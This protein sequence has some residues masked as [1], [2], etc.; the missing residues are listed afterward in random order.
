MPSAYEKQKAANIERNRQLLASLE[1]DSATTDLFKNK[2][3]KPKPTPKPKP[4][5]AAPK[6]R[7][8]P[9]A[10]GDEGPDTKAQ[11]VEAPADPEA[12]GVRRSARNAGKSVDYKAEQNKSIKTI[13]SFDH[14]R[15]SKNSGE[16]GKDNG[17]PKYPKRYGAIPG[18]EVGTWWQGRTGCRADSI[19]APLVAGISGNAEEGAYSI[20]L[21]GGYED[22]VDLGEAFTYTGSG[23]RDLRGTKDKPKNLRTAPQSS[24]QTFDN[25]FNA[26]LKRSCDNKRPVRVIRGFKLHSPF[27]PA[28]GYRYDG[29][30]I[31]EKAWREKGLNA[32]GFLVCKFALKRMPGQPPLP[33]R[34]DDDE[35]DSE[36]EE[37][38]DGVADAEKENEAVDE[39]EEEN[40]DSA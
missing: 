37:H 25:H 22:D 19:H 15:K 40:T 36:D 24:D 12:G 23:G 11:C 27:A 31:V 14:G 34:S 28:E 29:L 35:S 6:K 20:A 1:L 32:H 10:G 26:A 21:S 16:L 17:E 7:K 30:Y 5:K 2:P 33:V 39:D 38:S 9:P 8:E 3:Q 4:K 13:I 18:V